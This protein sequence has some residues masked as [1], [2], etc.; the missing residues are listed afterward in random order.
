MKIALTATLLACV[1]TG[2]LAQSQESYGQLHDAIK[3]CQPHVADNPELIIASCLKAID[4]GFVGGQS[5]AQAWNNVGGAHIILKQYDQ[6]ILAL[7]N[8]IAADPKLWRAYENRGAAEGAL[9][10]LDKAGADIDVAMQLAP[11]EPGPVRMQGQLFLAE[12][13][14]DDAVASFTAAIAN[15]SSDA[16]SYGLRA[17]VYDKLNQPDKAAADRAKLKELDPDN[18]YGMQ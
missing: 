4:S 10:E 6:A 8:A 12:R 13:R 17:Q 2:A 14:Y 15:D 9:G 7:N 11:K 3:Y 5:L 1:A 16:P 18:K